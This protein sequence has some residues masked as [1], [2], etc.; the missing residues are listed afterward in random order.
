MDHQE[1]QKKAWKRRLIID[2]Y[3]INQFINVVTFQVEL[4]TLISS[5]ACGLEKRKKS[6]SDC[7]LFVFSVVTYKKLTFGGKFN[8][9]TDLLGLF[10]LL[11]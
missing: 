9:V 8:Q 4:S 7:Q 11:L 6:L 5:I 2:N 3:A 10:A 1:G